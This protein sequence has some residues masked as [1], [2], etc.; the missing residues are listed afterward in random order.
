VLP[1]EEAIRRMTSLPCD[2]FGLASRGRIEEG[3]HA[4]LVLFD[5]K[6]VQDLATYEEPKQEPAGIEMVIVNGQ[7]ACE[8]GTHTGV[9]A[10]RML[11]HRREDA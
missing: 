6:N 9:G 10:G 2:R 1:L 3:Y 4:D 11:R 8:G 5:P 7:V